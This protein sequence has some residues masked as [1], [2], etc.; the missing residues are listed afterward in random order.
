MTENKKIKNA[1]AVQDGTL[2]FKSKLE[3]T[4][5]KTLLEFGITPQYEQHTFVLWEGFKPTVPFWTRDKNK[6]LAKKQTKLIS[7]TYTP[8]FVFDYNGFHVILEI[9]GFQND[10]FGLKFKMFRKYVESLPD[11]DRYVL[12]E[13]FTKTQLIEFINILK[14]SNREN[15]EE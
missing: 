12:A 15:P 3:H 8:D 6:C 9:K 13:I 2:Q 5:Y 11:K 1:T 4:A 10:V 7:I 14:F